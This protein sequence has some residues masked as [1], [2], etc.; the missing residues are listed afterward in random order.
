MPKPA[1]L[2]IIVLL[3]AAVVG[4]IY[5]I[6]THY[7]MQ[8]VTKE[9]RE[10]YDVITGKRVYLGNGQALKKVH[11]DEVCYLVFENSDGISVIPAVKQIGYKIKDKDN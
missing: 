3:I 8:I 6:I 5:C 9:L 11:V 4:I 10:E 1:I 2:G 7:P